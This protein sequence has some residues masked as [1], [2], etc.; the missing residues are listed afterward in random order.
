MSGLIAPVARL[1]EGRYERSGSAKLRQIVG[2][3]LSGGVDSSLIVG[4]MAEQ[5]VR[6]LWHCVH[7]CEQ[8]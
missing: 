2:A 4:L 6:E 5:G 8:R 1:I 3:L 7:H